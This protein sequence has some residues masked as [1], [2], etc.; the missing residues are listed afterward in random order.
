MNVSAISHV[1]PEGSADI[2]VVGSGPA[3]AITAVELARAGLKVIV[4]E[5]GDENAG[6]TASEGLGDLDVGGTAEIAFGR[7]FQLGGSTAL[8]AGRVAP[9]DS[10]DF[11]R[12]DWVPESGWPFPRGEIDHYYRRAY[13]I[14][15]VPYPD[16]FR[17]DLPCGLTNLLGS[18]SIEP[19]RLT[20]ANDPFHAGRW[21]RKQ[22]A[23]LPNLRIVLTAQAV[24]LRQTDHAEVRAIQVRRPDGAL[25]QIMARCFVIAAGGLETLRLLFNSTDCCADGLGNAHGALGRW[26]S[27]HPKADVAV[28]RLPRAAPTNNA[29]FAD[30]PFGGGRIRLGLGLDPVAQE[31]LRTLNHYVRLSPLA[32]FRASR[33]FE[34]VK[35]S[36]ILSSPFLSRQ[37]VSG[38]FLAGAGLWAFNAIGRCAKIQQRA[39]LL[40]VR[41]FFDQFPDSNNRLCRSDHKDDTGMP[42]LDIHWRFSDSDRRSVLAFLR[43]LDGELA[44]RRIGR[45]DFSGLAELSEWPI[46]ALHSHFM[47]GT[48]MGENPKSSVTDAFGRVH[49]VANLYI[50][51]PS[52]FPTFGFANPVLTIAALSLRLAKRIAGRQALVMGSATTR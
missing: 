3:G 46:T 40:V 36:R 9:L 15:G 50:A 39:R 47:G 43:R 26:F 48:R 20:W 21:L 16:G 6:I 13:D 29:V 30:T 41:G 23:L 49:G 38:G 28:V 12:R 34:L 33:A 37:A 27:T 32:E 31:E 8:W 1:M 11:V 42:K 45:M 5:A 24:A 25:D 35:G 44:R 14:L 18:G 52:L 10:I 51:G 7:A 17:G 2:C 19:K 22:V 4:L